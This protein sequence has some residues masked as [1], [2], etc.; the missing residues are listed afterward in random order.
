MSKANHLK[1]LIAKEERSITNLSAQLQKI[2]DQLDYHRD[3]LKY[4]QEQ[5]ELLQTK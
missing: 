4:Q 3:K 2:Q 1:D 5:L